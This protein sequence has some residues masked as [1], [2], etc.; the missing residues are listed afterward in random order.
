M[1]ASIRRTFEALEPSETISKRPISPVLATWV[2]PQSSRETPSTSTTRTQSPYFSPNSAIAP[3]RSASLRS[4][5]I[6][7]TGALSLIQPLTRSLDRASSSGVDRAPWVKSKRSLSGRT[8]EPGL[9]DVGAELLAQRRV[10]Q[11]GGGVVA[12]RRVAVDAGDLGLDACA[13]L[14]GASPRDPQRLVGA[15]AV[16]VDDLGLA[17]RSSESARVGHL[18]AA[19]GVEGALLELDQ[20]PP[21]RR[22]RA[23]AATPVSA[24]RSS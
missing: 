7:R 9:A 11:V 13:R 16:D 24:R 5:S 18:A 23:A 12:H 1:T 6:A 17:R 15:D 22:R 21:R 19:L 20:A 8:A 14:A 3:S 4:I 10:Q 2:P